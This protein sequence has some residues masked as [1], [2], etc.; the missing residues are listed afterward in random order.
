VPNP[1][2]ASNF[3]L[4]PCRTLTESQQKK[5]GVVRSAVSEVAKVDGS[6]CFFYLAPQGSIAV[7][8][9]YKDTSGLSR[10]YAEHANGMWTYWEPAAVDG[11][12]GVGYGSDQPDA[13]N[14]C[15]FAIG[16]TDA[17]FF[18]ATADDR[19]GTTRCSAAK[20][21]RQR[22]WRPCGSNQ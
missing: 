14:S 11:Y 2:K 21:S 15:N 20:R 1:L 9:A 17:L 18:W 10:R 7:V 6:S 19:D 3:T 8:I 16:V 12:P 4:D 13:R 5:F 22:C